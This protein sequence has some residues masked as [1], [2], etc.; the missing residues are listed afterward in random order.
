[1]P[2]QVFTVPFYFDYG[3]TFVWSVSG[4]LIAA[5]RGYDIAGVSALA[6]VSATGGGLL[7]DGLFLQNGPPALVRTPV[8]LLI[9]WLH[10]LSVLSLAAGDA[11]RDAVAAGQCRAQLWVGAGFPG[12]CDAH[13]G[14]LVSPQIHG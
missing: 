4:A 11:R 8:Y 14:D 9:V 6:L 12:R 7:R 1:M 3:A 2:D 5:R 13:T 10:D